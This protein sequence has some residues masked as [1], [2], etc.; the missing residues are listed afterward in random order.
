[1]SQ[2]ALW[3][4]CDRLIQNNPT[5]SC[6]ICTHMHKNT[7]YTHTAGV[8]GRLINSSL[9]T[10][11]FSLPHPHPLPAPRT[12]PKFSFQCGVSK[13]VSFPFY[14]KYADL[15]APTRQYFTCSPSE[16]DGWKMH[17]PSAGRSKSFWDMLVKYFPF[18]WIYC[19]WPYAILKGWRRFLITAGRA[20]AHD[21]KK[22][23]KIKNCL[24]ADYYME[25]TS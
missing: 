14:V 13:V 22:K 10:M 9:A 12:S 3:L 7:S 19:L 15:S 25:I 17:Q 11:P 18:I 24:K 23:V 4:F 8:V 5:F 16:R 2:I 21:S 1:V 20:G 6:Q